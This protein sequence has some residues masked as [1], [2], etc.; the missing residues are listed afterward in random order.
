MAASV[1]NPETRADP[2]AEAFTTN[3]RGPLEP[4]HLS[5][6]GNAR[7]LVALHGRDIRYVPAWETWLVYDG[8]RWARDD[9][10]GIYRR[11]KDVPMA[12][13]AEAGYTEDEATRRALVKHA[14]QS[15][16]E[17][18]IR[19]MV[20]LAQSEP[21]I[22]ARPDQLDADPWKLNVLNGTL[23]LSATREVHAHRRED[24]IT[25]LVPIVYDPTAEAPVFMAF[26]NRI[27][28]GNEQLIRFQQKFTGYSLTGDTSEQVLVIEHGTGANGKTTLNNARSAMLGDYARYTPI[29][30]LLE[31]SSDA[32]R[33]DVARLHGARLVV[34]IE[35]EFGKRLAE[36]LVKQLVG[37]DRVTARFLYREHFEFVP[38][39]KL[40]VATNH[41]PVI[42]GT[43]LAI[44]RRI[45]LVPFAVTIPPEEQDR[46]LPEKLRAEL[47]GI[48]RWAIEGCRLWQEEGLG[49][50]DAI[51]QAT[52]AYRDEMD[53]L[54]EF[55]GECC[56]E[57]PGAQAT[58]KGI[59]DVYTAWAQ[60]AGE[61]PVGIKTFARLVAGRGH[62]PIRTR[63][64]RG[65]VGIRLRGPDEAEPA[66]ISEA[67]P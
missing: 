44:W 26:L 57:E 65:W 2:F 56:V 49:L 8:M 28:D 46:K 3:G 67:T 27:F 17:R 33:N 16:S 60:R 39:F 30:T 41:K 35:G 62:Q 45:R 13:Y 47:P 15:E 4:E 40:V 6:L 42:R 31:R 20:K 66:W 14:L 64:W 38:T 7:R 25:K 61:K 52:D 34:A 53:A 58:T 63:A 51:K 5:D 10:G 37:G 54:G 23:D 22:P 59:Y 18:A 1:S 24:H 21:G 43:D 50:P 29:E 9:I 12:I 48:L 36:A 55:V 32:V 19:A 11:A